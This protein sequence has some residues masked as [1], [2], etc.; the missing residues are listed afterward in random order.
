VAI[1]SQRLRLLRTETPVNQRCNRQPLFH[2]ILRVRKLAVVEVHVPLRRRDIRVPEQPAGV[3]D[4]LLTANPHG[5]LI[6]QYQRLRDAKTLALCAL[7]CVGP[8]RASGA[9]EVLIAV[10]Y[11]QSLHLKEPRGSF[12]MRGR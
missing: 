11:L 8:E 12:E 9:P 3:L 2:E 6:R 1:A 4:S 5:S 10:P 7:R